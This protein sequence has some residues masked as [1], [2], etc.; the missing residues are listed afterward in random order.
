MTDGIKK[1]VDYIK[2]NDSYVEK[3]I[4]L[5]NAVWR[6]EKSNMP[7]LTLSCG[8]TEEQ[9]EWLPWSNYKEIHFDSEKMFVNGLRDVLGSVNGGYGAVPSMRANMGCGIMI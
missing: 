2:T 3:A 1:A 6:Q 9:N 5:Q 8:L 4:N 7:V